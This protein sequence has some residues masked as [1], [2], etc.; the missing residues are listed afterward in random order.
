M[1]IEKTEIDGLLIITPKVFED[2]RGHFFESFNKNIFL[3]N[4][5]DT[6]F[7]QDNQSLSYKN[8]L[9]GLHFQ[10]P[11]YAQAKLVSVIKGAVLDVAVDIR[12]NSKTFGKHFKLILSE[13][14][15][16]MLYIPVGFAHGFLAIE[17]NTVFSY[18]CGN[19]YHQESENSIFWND[20]TLNIE[21]GIK[22]PLVSEKDNSAVSFKSFT[23][24]F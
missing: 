17:D 20:E 13:K 16:T 1:Q 4:G 11:P 3:K 14:N 19:F 8:V 10:N 6:D 18:K 21:W 12:K 2:E 22:K 24:Q 5:I 15:K 23:S 7:V 9:R